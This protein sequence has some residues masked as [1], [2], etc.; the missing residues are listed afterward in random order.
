MIPN[1]RDDGE[2]LRRLRDRAWNL[3]QDL[4]RAVNGVGVD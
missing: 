4:K 1:A 3:A 2:K